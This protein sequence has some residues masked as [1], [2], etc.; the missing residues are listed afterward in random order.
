MRYYRG[1]NGRMADALT[2]GFQ[3][4]RQQRRENQERDIQRIAS[5]R[6]HHEMKQRLVFEQMAHRRVVVVNYYSPIAER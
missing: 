4:W 1:V 3:L 2:I 5:R 6:G